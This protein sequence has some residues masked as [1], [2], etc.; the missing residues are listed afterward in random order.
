M[1]DG[2]IAERGSH[3]HLVTKPNGEYANLIKTFHADQTNDDDVSASCDDVALDGVTSATSAADV[4]AVKGAT[5]VTV[6]AEEEG[7]LIEKEKVEKGQ[8]TKDTY[9]AYFRL[10]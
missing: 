4:E 5:E 2:R 10:V 8:V 1:K 6:D 9:L 3:L 7:K